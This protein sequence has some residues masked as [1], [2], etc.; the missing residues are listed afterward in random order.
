MT[1]A[2]ILS[3]IDLDTYTRV[4]IAYLRCCGIFNLC[5]ILLIFYP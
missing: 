3:E 2:L 4:S 1:R 5:I